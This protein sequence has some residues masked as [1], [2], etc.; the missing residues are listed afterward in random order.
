MPHLPQPARGRSF[1]APGAMRRPASETATGEKPAPH[2]KRAAP[3]TTP[4][5]D[6]AI[7]ADAP[8]SESHN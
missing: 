5:I 7:E 4:V 3:A 6:T 1:A 2:R 8:V